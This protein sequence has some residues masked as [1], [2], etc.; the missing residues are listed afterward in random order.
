MSKD[1]TS[2][3]SATATPVKVEAA[4]IQRSVSGLRSAPCC[5]RACVPRIQ[6]TR[7]IAATRVA[8]GVCPFCGHRLRITYKLTATEWIPTLA[9][10][11]TRQK[12]TSK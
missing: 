11:L 6:R 8:D 10:D 3:A 1:K 2:T 7:I 4:P 12:S 9:V 5:G